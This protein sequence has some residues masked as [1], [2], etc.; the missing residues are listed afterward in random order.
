MIDSP[1]TRISRQSTDTATTAVPG[2]RRVTVTG[3]ADAHLAQR[4]VTTVAARAADLLVRLAGFEAPAGNTW[5]D[6]FFYKRNK[7]SRKKK[8]KQRT[9]IPDGKEAIKNA[10]RLKRSQSHHENRKAILHILAFPS[11][12]H[13]S[14][15]P[16]CVQ[17]EEEKMARLSYEGGAL[18]LLSSFLLHVRLA[19]GVDNVFR[20]NILVELRSAAEAAPRSAVVA[21]SIG[22]PAA[23]FA[24]HDFAH[25]CSVPSLYNIYIYIYIYFKKNSAG[26]LVVVKAIAHPP[27]TAEIWCI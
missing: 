14:Q 24:A 13:Q 15:A 23:P 8:K 12:Y 3:H 4:R 27:N 10:T 9:R 16:T 26:F 22:D 20:M 11:C 17:K 25:Q 6:L 7:K 5:L 2:V 18:A 21:E 1:A 19:R